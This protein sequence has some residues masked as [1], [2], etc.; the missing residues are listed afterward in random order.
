MKILQLLFPAMYVMN[1]LLIMESMQNVVYR[2]F[3]VV[4]Q[5]ISENDNAPGKF[6]KKSENDS[7]NI[8]K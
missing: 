5:N 3:K 8:A 2:A 1:C 7:S 6:H 4:K